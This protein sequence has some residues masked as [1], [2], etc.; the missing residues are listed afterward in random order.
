[1]GQCPPDSGFNCEDIKN[2]TWLAKLPYTIQ[3][4]VNQRMAT[5]VY[6]RSNFTILDIYDLSAPLPANYTPALF[7]QALNSV[8]IGASDSL[9]LNNAFLSIITTESLVQVDY[10]T[11]GQPSNE[12]DILTHL[13]RLMTTPML[14][15]NIPFL[16]GEQ[17]AS[18]PDTPGN[19]TAAFAVPHERVPYLK[20]HMH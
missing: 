15:Y 4:T 20:Y 8:L 7:L 5:T 3:M 6:D 13:K 10:P 16:N 17:A 2:T 1:M 14:V 9:L 11:N 18:G 19:Y 12:V